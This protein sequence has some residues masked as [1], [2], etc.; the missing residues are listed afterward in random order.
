MYEYKQEAAPKV[1]RSS[2]IDGLVT[3]MASVVQNGTGGGAAGVALAG[4]TG[5]TQDYRDVWFDGFSNDYVAIVWFGNDDNTS[6]K[7]ATGGGLAAGTW[8]RIVSAAKADP[9]PSKYKLM[10]SYDFGDE[11]GD[12]LGRIM[13]E[14]RPAM[15]NEAQQP[16]F[17]EGLTTRPVFRPDHAGDRVGYGRMND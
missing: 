7:G 16:G 10:K 1:F 15:D 12:M 13:S 4:K 14:D 5:T 11:F 8:K 17:L 3:M 9:S 6:M 2:D